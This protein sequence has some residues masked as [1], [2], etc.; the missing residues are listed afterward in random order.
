[1]GRAMKEWGLRIGVLSAFGW[2]FLGAQ[3]APSLDKA[4]EALK[5]ADRPFAQG[6]EAF[7]QGRYQDAVPLFE[8]CVEILPRH[9]YAR[10]YLANLAYIKADYGLALTEMERSVQDLDFMKE[11]GDHGVKM[12]LKKIESYERMVAKEWDNTLN[13]R[14]SRELESIDGQLTDTKSRMELEARRADEART[15]QKAQFV[16]FL[17]NILF[18][19]QRRPEA[20]QKYREAIEL[21]PRHPDAYNNLTA[22]AYLAGDFPTAGSYLEEAEK[23]GLEDNLNLKLKHLVFE[24]LGRPTEGILREDL[25]APGEDGLGVFRF[26][27]AYKVPGGLGPPLYVNAYIVFDR[28]TRNALLIDPGV[29]DPR[30]GEFVGERGLTVKAILL[31]HGHPDH[32]GACA[33]FARLFGAPVLAGRP[34]AKTYGLPADRPLEDGGSLD[35]DGLAVEILATPG[36]TAG[37]LCFLIGDHLFSGDTL[38]RGFIGKLAEDDPAKARKAGEAL[39]RTIRRKLLTLPGRTRVCPGHGV[40]TTIADEASANPFL[41]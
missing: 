29:E 31:T 1:M 39:I 36:H 30:I 32:A 2:S 23:L 5:S 14:Q 12:K 13:C 22:I 19:L 35:L 26:A 6:M 40:M 15:K 3:S 7:N 17:G 18:Q 33:S 25:S 11:L 28:E 4:W 27:L 41:K 16:Y 37:S 21:D 38:F 9:A 24:A 10:Y 20:A 34:D 8:K